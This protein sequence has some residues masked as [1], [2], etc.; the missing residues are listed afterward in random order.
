M[1]IRKLKKTIL[2]PS[3]MNDQLLAISAS[4]GQSVPAIILGAIQSRLKNWKDPSTGKRPEEVWPSGWPKQA[5]CFECKGLHDPFDVA[6]DHHL[7]RIPQW[8]LDELPELRKIYRAKTKPKTERES[9]V[10]FPS[11]G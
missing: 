2:V 7:K 10:D 4:T 8:A 11:A 9:N 6:W 1:K 3:A 5:A